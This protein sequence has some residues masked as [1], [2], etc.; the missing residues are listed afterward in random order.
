MRILALLTLIV[1]PHFLTA[2]HATTA[3]TTASTEPLT[4]QWGMCRILGGRQLQEDTAS[5]ITC[6]A[7]DADKGFFGVYDGH[8]GTQVSNEV[9]EGLHTFLENKMRAGKQCDERLFRESFQTMSDVLDENAAY[10][11][12]STAVTAII[13]AATQTAH[14]A[15]A[16][17]A[18]ACLL[19]DGKIITHTTDHV[20]SDPG[21][22]QRIKDSFSNAIILDH[23]NRPVRSVQDIDP[24]LAKTIRL[25]G[26]INL[27]RGFG[28]LGHVENGLIC[29]PEVVD[30]KLDESRTLLLCSDGL[31]DVSAAAYSSIRQEWIEANEIA[32]DDAKV[33]ER[34]ERFA[35]DDYV[36]AGNCEQLE[37]LA[38]IMCNSSQKAQDLAKLLQDSNPDLQDQTF[39]YDNVTIMLVRLARVT[40]LIQNTREEFIVTNPVPV[41]KDVQTSELSEDD[42]DDSNSSDVEVV[43]VTRRIVPKDKR[44]SDD[45]EDS[46]DNQAQEE[47]QGAMAS[48]HSGDIPPFMRPDLQAGGLQADG[49][50][51]DLP[52]QLAGSPA[53]SK[54]ISWFKCIVDFIVGLNS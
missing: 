23:K 11:E 53:S 6:F 38:K 25:G 39:P 18:R 52:I 21:E 35:Q 48:P 22:F 7:G 20:P 29:M 1:S 33:Q 5:V 50:Q 13:D 2:A 32:A 16:G 9:A 15:W 37:L 34:L 27:S 24:L 36:S 31:V 19:Q 40:Q 10:N 12:G 14:V 41:K 45:E 42:S 43:V 54:G 8:G 3:S 44:S 26:D 47:T 30:L 51:A 28:D 49:M 46:E 4:I 17:D